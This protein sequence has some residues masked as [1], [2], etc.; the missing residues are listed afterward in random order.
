MFHWLTHADSTRVLWGQTVVYTAYSLAIISLMAWFAYKVVK[1]EGKLKITP[2]IFYT[3]VCCLVVLGVALHVIT[4][5]TIPWAKDELFGAKSEKT[6]SLGVGKAKN[7]GGAQDDTTPGWYI[8]DGSGWQPLEAATTDPKQPIQICQ[9]KLV[10][11]SVTS[12]DLTYGFGI[13][14]A[15]NSLVAQIQVVPGHSNE[16][17]WKFTK[18]GVYSVRST[19][20][21]GPDQVKKLFAKD[22]IEVG[23]PSSA[24]CQNWGSGQ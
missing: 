11:F 20:Y 5:S 13:I 3:W 8:K 9:D 21:S 19:E 22:V 24:V 15:N 2:K 1:P 4:F 10:E 17:Q 12:P 6:F 7:F 23:D 14:R 18:A 16:L